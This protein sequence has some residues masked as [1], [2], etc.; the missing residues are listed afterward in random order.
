MKK[1]V[2]WLMLL[3]LAG[4]AL[5][6]CSF[7]ARQEPTALAAFDALAGR[8]PADVENAFFF[9]FK[10][11]D[12]TGQHWTAIRDRLQQNPATQQPLADLLARFHVEAYQLDSVIEGPA[13]AAQWGDT[14]LVLLPVQ[15]EAA[16]WEG[17]VRNLGDAQ[18]WEQEIVQGKLIYH[19][20]FWESGRP[21]F[22]AWT[23][24]E[25]LLYL[26]YRSNGR[27]VD[28]LSDLLGLARGATLDSLDPWELLQQ[29][30]PDA[31]LAVA[32]L[33][34]AELAGRPAPVRVDVSPLAPED[35]PPSAA[36]ERHLEA[37]ALAFTPEDTGLRLDIQGLLGSE[38]G[39]VPA[40]QAL[41]TLPAV[42]AA[43]WDRLP[44]N[45]AVALFGHS[46]S[47]IW[48]WFSGIFG[49]DLGPG[50]PFDT[51]VGL[52][53]ETDLLREGGPLAGP[54]A[55]A[56]TPPL[57][58]QPISQ[59]LPA[60]QALLV[61]KDV[62][63][64]QVDRLAATLEGRGAVLATGEVAG[65]EVQTQVGTQLSGYALSFG[66]DGDTLYV[67]TSPEIIHRA[68]VAGSGDSGLV[69]TAAFQTILAQLPEDSF[70]LGYVSSRAS[71]ELLRANAGGEQ[72]PASSAIQILE[73]FD[74]MG[75]GLRLESGQA[76]D[77]G[78]GRVEGVA[79]FL[80]EE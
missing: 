4:L 21:T 75:V 43:G 14:T 79:Y 25:D 46:A 31:P 13:A 51:A 1:A 61:G 67:G 16:A 64:A 63:P 45:T 19:A 34:V 56:V 73:T 35:Q 10:P 12:R 71:I 58:E 47:T 72:D 77:A 3:I 8:L 41:F 65:L 26:A 30:L 66:L 54:F 74:A 42:E 49:L 80:M 2:C 68:V 29:R 40:L 33:P 76:G 20:R 57:P 70:L 52:D 62:A 53:L 69:G 37:L 44:A 5:G 50:T 9:N 78:L 17:M 59:G 55:L 7:G 39:T 15:D 27:S 48:P 11:D 22:L 60:L 32:F 18:S 24:D 38:A 23:M 28:P 36:L 6:A